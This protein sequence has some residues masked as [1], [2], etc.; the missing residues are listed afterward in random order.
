MAEYTSPLNK[1]GLR[2][3]NAPGIGEVFGAAYH[4]SSCISIPPT[5]NIYETCGITGFKS[6]KLDYPSDLTEEITKAFQNVEDALKAGGV[7]DGWKAVYKM[8]SYH[9]GD[10]ESHEKALEEVVGKYFG[11]NRPAWAGVRV[12]ELSGGARIELVVSAVGPAK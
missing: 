10:M 9:V 7:E 6:E 1:H 4:I 11:E 8:T 5:S 12:V 2:C 3:F